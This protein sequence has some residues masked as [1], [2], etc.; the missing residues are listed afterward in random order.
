MARGFGLFILG[1]TAM[2]LIGATLVAA[3]VPSNHVDLMFL[4]LPLFG[5]S[6]AGMIVVWTGV[7]FSEWIQSVI[8]RRAD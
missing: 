7:A 8:R 6:V 2:G 5:V 3:T 1:V 4:F